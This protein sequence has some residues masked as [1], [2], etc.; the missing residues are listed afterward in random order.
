MPSALRS[1]KSLV[2][3]SVVLRRIPYP[4]LEFSPLLFFEDYRNR[5]FFF[6]SGHKNKASSSHSPT[7]RR[8]CYCSQLELVPPNFPLQALIMEILPPY[9][10]CHLE[11]DSG[12]MYCFRLRQAQELSQSIIP[13]PGGRVSSGTVYSFRV[14]SGLVP[15]RVELS[16]GVVPPASIPVR[17]AFA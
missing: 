7:T 16:L 9:D 10:S 13:A 5:P 6:V 3:S 4:L 11:N 14:S 1:F 12:G 8:C 17:L 2:T 15:S